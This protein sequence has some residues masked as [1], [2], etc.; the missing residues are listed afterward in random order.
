MAHISAY[1][2]IMVIATFVFAVVKK[3]LTASLVTPEDFARRR[4]VWFGLTSAA[5][6]SHNFWLYIAISA[7]IVLH[8][9]QKERNPMA[10]YFLVFAAVP[11]FDMPI[12]GFGVVN[13]VFDMNHVR[14]MAM[15]I[16][17]PV[18]FRLVQTKEYVSST[19]R[20]AHRILLAYMGL[21]FAL[22]ASHITT[23]NILREAL[24]LFLG[25]WLPFFVASRSLRDIRQL[26]EALTM[27]VLGFSV[28]GLVAVFE[29]TRSW[30]LYETLRAPFGA[31][32]AALTFYLLR[33]T[34]GGGVLRAITTL[35]HSIVL[36]YAMG[37]GICIWA[38]LRHSIKPSN[39]SYFVLACIFAGFAAAFS[40]GPWVGMVAGMLF[41]S[42]LGPNFF[43][44]MVG[45]GAFCL[46]AFAAL[47][48]TPYGQ[49][50]YAYLP[51]VGS[52]SSDTVDYRVRLF[53]VSMEVFWDSPVFGNFK[54]MFD[55]RMEEM[56]QGQG[57]IDM[58][59]SYLGVAMKFGMVGLV[60]FLLPF[61]VV[62][63]MASKTAREVEPLHQSM[64]MT[65]RSLAGILVGTLLT[66]ATASS[67][68]FVP[69]L[70]WP[71]LGTAAAFVGIANRWKAA[72]R[73]SAARGLHP[74]RRPP[75]KAQAP[76][77]GIAGPRQG[78]RDAEPTGALGHGFGSTR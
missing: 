1:V 29:T 20:V 9:M 60:L 43:K 35:G 55:P 52:V 30:I 67:V 5:F 41:L 58:V 51:F 65:G 73:V 17:A 24:Y 66:I 18:A 39:M 75:P 62:I 76:Q 8:A 13:F 3:P 6:L 54:Y 72:Q 27:L 69:V 19:Y 26:R 32:P 74:S 14:L 68:D 56:R 71:L 2:Y 63:F 40:R 34:E 16:L 23:A 42:L 10:L 48:F 21:A 47:L 38:A 28:L 57:I 70:Y 49:K 7:V 53:E 4:N 36:G 78:N 77:G 12:P 37:I 31:P 25:T 61:L 44:R 45:V 46:V 59:N 50:L 33:E 22:A 15:I 64:G 11:I